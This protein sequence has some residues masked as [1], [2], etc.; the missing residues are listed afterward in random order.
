MGYRYLSIEVDSRLPVD[1]RI[2]C[3]SD[4]W[5]KKSREQYA[6]E[7]HY[8]PG[9]SVRYRE[10]DLPKI[11]DI[12]GVLSDETYH[13]DLKNESPFPNGGTITCVCTIPILKPDALNFTYDETSDETF[14]ARYY[15]TL[16]FQ[17]FRQV[18][19]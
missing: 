19:S 3:D 13:I 2:S 16:Y 11:R 12:R 5:L 17:E 18:T 4:S 10:P 1:M 6:R 9:E 15:G 8:D 7:Q 14:N